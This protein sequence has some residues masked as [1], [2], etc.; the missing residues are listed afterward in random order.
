MTD[1]QMGPGEALERFSTDLALART[2]EAAAEVVTGDAEQS[3]AEAQDF[4]DGARSALRNASSD[5]EHLEDTAVSAIEA[6]ASSG[7]YA[8]GQLEEAILAARGKSEEEIEEYFKHFE[9]I[10]EEEQPVIVIAGSAEDLGVSG[11]TTVTYGRTAGPDDLRAFLKYTRPVGRADD[12]GKASSRPGERNIKIV[13]KSRRGFVLDDRHDYPTDLFAQADG[14]GRFDTVPANGNQ[15][16][17]RVHFAGSAEEVQKT[18]EDVGAERDKTIDDLGAL[19]LLGVPTMVAYGDEAVTELT[20]IIGENSPRENEMLVRRCIDGLGIGSSVLG[21]LPEI[22]DGRMMSSFG[23]HL[24]E[25]F[26]SA[27]MIHLSENGP[28]DMADPDAD[29]S[30]TLAFLGPMQDAIGFSPK[31]VLSRIVRS[32][33][34]G[35]TYSFDEGRVV[36]SKSTAPYAVESG[37]NYVASDLGKFGVQPSEGSEDLPVAAQRVKTSVI[38]RERDITPKIHFRKR[39]KLNKALEEI[40]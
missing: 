14:D 37:V 32:I 40:E 19:K 35:A 22:E 5:R 2:R 28:K 30:R 34:I 24:Y 31:S 9:R 27:L 21:T 20:K 4:L 8:V 10:N 39:A 23:Q 38:L 6:A 13:A 25:K 7:F 36:I 16:F 11:L 33:A 18:I 17:E 26:N 15:P 12:D 1:Q 3:A 29:S